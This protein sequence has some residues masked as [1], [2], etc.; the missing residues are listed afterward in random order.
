MIKK[1]W[2][3][4]LQY[5][6]KYGKVFVN[7]NEFIETM[8]YLKALAKVKLLR[9]DKFGIDIKRINQRMK[10]I[11]EHESYLNQILYNIQLDNR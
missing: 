9:P 6:M 1:Q 8:E 7:Y 4:Y 10:Q 11:L 2:E 5:G 3:Q